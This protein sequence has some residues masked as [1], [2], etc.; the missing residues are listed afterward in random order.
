M[1][2]LGEGSP[3]TNS[4][5]RTGFRVVPVKRSEHFFNSCDFDFFRRSIGANYLLFGSPGLLVPIVAVP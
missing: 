5:Y 4:D 2:K 1:R 3:G